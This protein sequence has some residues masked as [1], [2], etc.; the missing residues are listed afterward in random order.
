[1]MLYSYSAMMLLRVCL[2]RVCSAP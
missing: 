1:M 2:F